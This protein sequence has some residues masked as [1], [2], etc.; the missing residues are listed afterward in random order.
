MGSRSR[1]MSLVDRV[2]VDNDKLIGQAV[3]WFISKQEPENVEFTKY[4]NGYTIEVRTDEKN[5]EE[6]KEFWN[7]YVHPELG[8]DE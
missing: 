6:A 8:G 7:Q 1:F 2:P 5:A 4:Q 3:G